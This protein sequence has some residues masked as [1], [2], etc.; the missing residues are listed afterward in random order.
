MNIN[1][2]HIDILYATFRNRLIMFVG[3][4]IFAAILL[5]I[6][7]H[8][9]NANFKKQ[10]A[11]KKKMRQSYQKKYDDTITRIVL[12]IIVIPIVFIMW[13]LPPYQDATNNS[14]IQ[15]E[16]IYYRSK[17][18]F[19][20][21]YPNVGGTIRLEIGEDSISV[22][23]HPGFSERDFPEGTYPAMVWYGE[24]SRVLLEVDIMEN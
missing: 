22:E 5:T 3:L 15:T 11:R 24:K 6:Q 14:I 2:H 1:E 12:A 13:V 19:S 16:A 10:S 8:F 21:H 4:V 20:S 23:L 9:A 18:D 17:T 7:Y